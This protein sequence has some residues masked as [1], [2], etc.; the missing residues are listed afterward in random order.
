MKKTLIIAEIGVNHN[1]D[2]SLAKEMAGV[3]KKCGVDIVKYQ[4]GI[5]EKII[6]KFAPKAEYQKE[7]TGTSES[8]LEMIKKVMLPLEAFIE[9]K[10]Y[11]D[12]IG[13]KF[14]STPFDLDSVTFLDE[15]DI[16]L[17]KIP[18]GEVT[19]LPYLI[20]IAQTKKPIIMSTGMCNINE[21]REAVEC[22]RNNGS[23]EISLLHCT[24]EY[25]TPMNEV[26]LKAI[27]TMRDEFGLEIGY[28]DH[29]I[30]IEVPIA[31]VA[32]GATII[33]KH[34]TLD[35]TMEG[36]DHRASIEPNELKKM[37]DA[38]RNIEI[39]IG[40][41]NKIPSESEL[42]N[43]DIARKS[44]VASRIIQKGEM[45]TEENVTVKRPGTGISPMRVYE[46]LGT[47]AKK[48]FLEDEIIEI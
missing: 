7:T 29:T 19:N 25:P 44:L 14:L 12:E 31:A 24:T 47:Y 1:G 37:V 30:G 39:A 45:F 42:K 33:E 3:A 48:K 18:S 20:K 15:M 13:I 10:K 21:I 32:R 4:T 27:D 28:S 5:P 17:W 23:T 38:I 26:N 41:G 9:I 6:S 22:L 2:I 40:N 43:R 35:K 8:Q 11:C 34:F 46:V 36:P 16:D